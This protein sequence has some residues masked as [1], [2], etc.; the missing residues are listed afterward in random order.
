MTDKVH[1]IDDSQRTA[2]RVAGL[3][4][5]ISMLFILTAN[6][7]LR[8]SIF[9]PGDIPGTIQRVAASASLF[10]LSIA[11]DLFYSVGAVVTFVAQYVVLSRVSKHLALLAS[12]LKLVYAITAVLIALSLLNLVRLATDVAYQGLQP[13]AL[14]AL[15]RVNY[16]ATG[17]QYYVGLAFWA[18]SSTVFSWLWLKSGYIPAALAMFGIAASAWCVFCTFAYIINPGFSNVVNLWWFDSPFAVF[19]IVLSFWLLFKGLRGPS[20]ADET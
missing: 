11:F 18:L 7:G 16:T 13:E 17:M 20:T 8:G 14:Q 19:D 4:Y 2:A 15:F 1:F 12:M 9:V 3:G 6:F 10:R 5:L